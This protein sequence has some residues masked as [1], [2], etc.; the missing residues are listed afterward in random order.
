MT[1]PFIIAVWEGGRA[2][3]TMQRSLSLC[4]CCNLNYTSCFAFT[5]QRR[6]EKD[7]L[8]CL[9]AGNMQIVW[10]VAVAH[11]TVCVAIAH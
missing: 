2:D 7:L 9:A 6:I 4:V 11:L 5:W 3:P 10:T 1:T 8:C